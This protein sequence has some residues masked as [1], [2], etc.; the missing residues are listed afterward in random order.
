M[1]SLC[2]HIHWLRCC[3]SV[4]RPDRC[5]MSP[6]TALSQYQSILAA[7]SAGL[8]SLWDLRTASRIA[9]LQLGEEQQVL[10]LQLDEWKLLSAV[11]GSSKVHMYDIRALSSGLLL[12]TSWPSPVKTFQAASDVQCFQVLVWQSVLP[13]PTPVLRK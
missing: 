2:L 4:C 11:R 13:L 12:D 10:G 8:I 5:G 6:Y 9:H 1:P 3:G 7:G